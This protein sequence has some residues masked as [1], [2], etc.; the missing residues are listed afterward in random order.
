LI[1]NTEKPL[2]LKHIVFDCDGVL[3]D[4]TNEGYVQ[5]YHR[6]ALEAG[7]A[8]DYALANQRILANWGT[9]A[10][11]EIEGLL[12]DHPHLVAIECA[13]DSPHRGRSAGL[14]RADA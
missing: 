13:C 7:A 12:P 2:M 4:G 3:W 11:Q 8:I 1:Y 10:Q 14:D 9:S 5:C 6:A